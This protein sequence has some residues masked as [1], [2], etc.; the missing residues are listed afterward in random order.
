MRETMGDRHLPSFGIPVLLAQCAV[1]LTGCFLLPKPVPPPAPGPEGC[2]PPPP[3]VFR[4]VGVDLN[5]AQSTFGE[6]VVGTIDV[7]AK[8]EVVNLASQA[9]TDA[10]IVEY[11]RC[12][13]IKRDGYTVEQANYLQ[14]LVGFM[15]AKPTAQ[16]FIDWKK[17]NKFPGKAPVVN[18][19][20]SIHIP[21][22]WN[23]KEGATSIAK[24][25]KKSVE[26]SG[27]TDQELAAP[28]SE[29]RLEVTSHSKLLEGLKNYVN[30][31]F[32]RYEVTYEEPTFKIKALR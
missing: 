4:Q 16:Q 29:V 25:A 20:S 30:T 7:K 32:P 11:M 23:F 24:H 21:A 13:A 26:F 19:S 9:A 15:A 14:E 8:P 18:P 10:Q 22:G 12:L 31:T 2:Q 5:F 28:L 27:F 6:L 1:F 17:E 3:T